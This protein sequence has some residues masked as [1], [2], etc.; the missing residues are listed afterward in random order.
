MSKSANSPKL[1]YVAKW[2]G[3][4][5]RDTRTNRVGLILEAVTV[6]GEV[7]IQCAFP[8]GH[9]PLVS[10]SKTDD[11]ECLVPG[12]ARARYRFELEA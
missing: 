5:V 12:Y 4:Q 1:E 2:R 6:E 11:L 3:R 8:E 7:K 9:R 10:L